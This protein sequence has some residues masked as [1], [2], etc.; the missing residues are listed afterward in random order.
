MFDRRTQ[1]LLRRPIVVI[2]AQP[3]VGDALP[4]PRS[5]LGLVRLLDLTLYERSTS[6]LG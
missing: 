6:A 4:R 2:Y 1:D 3:W 5:V